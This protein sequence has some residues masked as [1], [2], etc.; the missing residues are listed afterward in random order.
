YIELYQHITGETFV[1]G[2]SADVLKRIENNVLEA[3][4]TL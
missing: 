3:L 4:R 2:D 1:K